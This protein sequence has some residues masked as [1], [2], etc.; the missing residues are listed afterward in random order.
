MFD[1]QFS[2]KIT[3]KRNRSGESLELDQRRTKIRENTNGVMALSYVGPIFEIIDIENFF[4]EVISSEKLS[5]DIGGTGEFKVSF[6]GI[7]DGKEKNFPQNIDHKIILLQEP[8]CLDD[9][10]NVQLKGFSK[11]KPRGKI[12]Q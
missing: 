6:R 5:M 8:T 4:E 7:I 12:S 11:F 3:I 1:S 10:E 9:R 2:N